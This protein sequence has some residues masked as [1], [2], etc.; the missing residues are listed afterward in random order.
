M[1]SRR[2]LNNSVWIALA[3]ALPGV[4][5]AQSDAKWQTKTEN[6]TRY[7]IYTGSATVAGKPVA[8]A[9]TFFC[10][11]TSTRNEKGMLGIEIQFN[12]VATLKGFPF[13]AFEGPDASTHGKKLLRLTVLR[14][15]KPDTKVDTH[16]NGWMP[17]SNQFTFGTAAESQASKSIEKTVLQALASDAD[18][19]RLTITH[20]R[21]PA[22]K[23]EVQVPVAAKR[24]DFKALL[25]GLK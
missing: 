15:G 6:G 13:D 14:T 4:A 5:S 16:V 22:S 11:P 1:I 9:V 24:E 18:A 7:L 19:I 2:T 23:L 3:A 25:A 10:N 12:Q 21:N 20:P 8:H 17:D